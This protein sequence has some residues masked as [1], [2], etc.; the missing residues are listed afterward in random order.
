LQNLR[1]KEEKTGNAALYGYL[2]ATEL[3][4]YLARKG[5]PFREGHEL[6]GK[7]VLR[8]IELGKE[9]GELGL[10]EMR[11]FSTVI[12]SDVFAALSLEETLKT[13]NATGGTSRERVGE[14]LSE[15]RRYLTDFV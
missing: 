9:L 15:A 4:D 8:A 2:N 5:I 7:I 14:A 12:E 1:V 11:R 3:A 6:V 10:D 13:K